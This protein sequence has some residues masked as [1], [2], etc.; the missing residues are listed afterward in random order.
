MAGKAR[1]LFGSALV[2]YILPT[3]VVGVLLGMTLFSIYKDDV[4]ST[5]IAA[6]NNSQVE[7]G[8]MAMNPS[9]ET[10]SSLAS[11]GNENPSETPEDPPPTLGDPE[12]D[13]TSCTDG[14]C[15]MTFKGVGLTGIPED[16]S[17]FIETSGPASGTDTIAAILNEV[18]QIYE[19]DGVT[20]NDPL[21]LA[22]QKLASDCAK[23]IPWPTNGG[24]NDGMASIQQ[25]LE[26]D[27]LDGSLDNG[28]ILEMLREGS[29][30]KYDNTIEYYNEAIAELQSM[31]PSPEVDKVESL[32]NLLYG[33]VQNVNNTFVNEIDANNYDMNSIKAHIASN[34]TDIRAQLINI[35]GE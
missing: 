28:Y 25:D 4:M 18:A 7:E 32:L 16:F 20:E 14:M 11:E 29:A 2:D 15:T 8:V 19:D 1:Y 34:S 27:L 33:E 12:E 10:V 22:L 9:V 17:E 30:S 24:P 6:S 3:A 13:L 31:S 26:T 5:F 35:L 21:A 23:D